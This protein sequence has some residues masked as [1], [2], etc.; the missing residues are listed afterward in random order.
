MGIN[1]VINHGG[2]IHTRVSDGV[3]EYGYLRGTEGGIGGDFLRH[4]PT[5][6]RQQVIAIIDA[7]QVS[8]AAWEAHL[9]ATHPAIWTW[10]AALPPAELVARYNTDRLTRGL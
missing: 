3:T 10:L 8:Q 5:I 4:G 2:A 9:Q 6:G 7:A 1:G